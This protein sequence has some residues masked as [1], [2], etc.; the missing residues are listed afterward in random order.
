MSRKILCATDGSEHSGHATEFAADLAKQ[1]G[2]ELVYLLVNPV[3]LTRGTRSL[4]FDDKTVKKALNA[5]AAVAKKAGVKNVKCVDH[6]ARDVGNAIVAYAEEHGVDQIVVGSGGK[7]ATSRLF[8][9]STSNDVVNKAHCPV[10]V[11]R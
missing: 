1:N 2:G 4:L 6:S 11:V 5:A 8:I 10:T 9:G 7:G 3:L